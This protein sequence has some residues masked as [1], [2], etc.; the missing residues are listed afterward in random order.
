MFNITLNLVWSFWFWFTSWNWN[1]SNR[2]Q[3]LTDLAPGTARPDA[4]L[5]VAYLHTCHLC[6]SAQSRQWAQRESEE[7]RH[8]WSRSAS[9]VCWSPS[10]NWP[11]LKTNS[12]EA[13]VY[14]S[15]YLSLT[16]PP[17]HCSYKFMFDSHSLQRLHCTEKNNAKTKHI[18]LQI[19]HS[20]GCFVSDMFVVV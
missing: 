11:H 1:G 7:P 20:Q 14:T 3:W 2:G 18:Y 8:T 17:Q 9:R 4:G 13:W 15:A 5:A 19:N 16:A 10:A 6:F 12:G